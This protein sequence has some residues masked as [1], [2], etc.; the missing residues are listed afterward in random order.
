VSNERT[1]THTTGEPFA[2]TYLH[3]K[4]RRGYDLCDVQRIVRGEKLAKGAKTIGDGK[5]SELA[6]WGHSEKMS[7]NS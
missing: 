2:H 6:S 4:D 7:I 1:T 3:A 5:F